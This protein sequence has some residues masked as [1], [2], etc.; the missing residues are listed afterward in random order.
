METPVNY[1]PDNTRMEV[2]PPFFLQRIYDFD[3]MLVVIPSRLVP[4]AYVIAR[5]RQYGVGLTAKAIESTIDQPDTKMCLTHGLVP[6][7]LMFKTG[8][9]WNVDALLLKL[10]AR[11]MWT[12]GGGPGKTSEERGNAVADMLEAQEAAEKEAVRKAIRD[13]IWNRSG[14]GWRTYQARTG[15]SN[16]RF[17]DRFKLKPGIG[18]PDVKTVPSGSTAGSGIFQND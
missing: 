13:D 5:R 6:V 17:K 8:P 2:P 1:I 15:A 11:D 16:L 9:V 4:N 12:I 7:C 10:A 3:S 18:T 14:D